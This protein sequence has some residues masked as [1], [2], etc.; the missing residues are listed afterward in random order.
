MNEPAYR[1]FF[2]RGVDL[3]RDKLEI[4]VCA[5]HSNGGLRGNMWWEASI[6]HL[7]PVG[8]V[9]GSHGVR[10]PGGA[11]LNAG[12]VGGIRA[13]LYISRRYD[14]PPP[15]VEAFGD[16]VRPQVS[17][18]LN[19]A[20]RMLAAGGRQNGLRPDRAIAE[21]Q[22]RMSTCAAIIRDPIRIGEEVKAAWRLLEEGRQQMAV[23]SAS[24]LPLAFRA[25]DLA[26]THVVYLEALREYLARDGG[27]R[28]SFLV[29]DRQGQALHERLGE[30]WRCIMPDRPA[31]AAS[32]IL[33]IRLEDGGR[34]RT[35][36]VDPRPIPRAAGWF[37]TVWDDY[38][39]DRVVR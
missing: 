38:R 8:E 33:E 26:L 17:Q 18:Y 31:S 15:E 22:N 39:H 30:S 23:S 13:A 6:G 32:P 34:I 4:A 36:W 10:R 14:G 27:S 19:Q 29:L 20:R 2:E 35:E 5:Q 25:L 16:E 12:Q 11:A 3:A 7:F 37:E 24:E 21:I 9:N 1:L 28:G